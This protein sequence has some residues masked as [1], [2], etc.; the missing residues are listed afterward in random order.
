MSLEK[1]SEGIKIPLRFKNS[2]YRKN[3]M[4]LLSITLQ[5]NCSLE[6][7]VLNFGDVYDIPRGVLYCYSHFADKEKEVQ[8]KK[9]IYSR[10]RASQWL[11]HQ[12]RLLM[13]PVVLCTAQKLLH[14][15]RRADTSSTLT[16]PVQEFLVHRV[17]EG[18]TQFAHL[19]TGRSPSLSG[20]TT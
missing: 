14:S 13:R 19:Q 20:K 8:R 18:L 10:F 9:V 2:L 16:H 12:I 1:N 7:F 6:Y 5:K 4:S 17:L 11:R 15:I 3:A